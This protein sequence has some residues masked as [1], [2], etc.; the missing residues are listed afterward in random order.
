M[1]QSCTDLDELITIDVC[2][3]AKLECFSCKDVRIKNF[4]RI[5]Y[6]DG[7]FKVRTNAIFLKYPQLD[8]TST[9]IEIVYLRIIMKDSAGYEYEIRR[10]KCDALK[11]DDEIIIQNEITMFSISEKTIDLIINNFNVLSKNDFSLTNLRRII[12]NKKSSSTIYFTE[13]HPSFSS[14]S[15]EKCWFKGSVLN[16]VIGLEISINSSTIIFLQ[17]EITGFHLSPNNN[18]FAKTDIKNYLRFLKI[19][20]QFIE[21]ERKNQGNYDVNDFKLYN[22][23]SRIEIQKDEKRMKYSLF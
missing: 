1:N 12:L 11:F 21:I 15:E 2:N 6:L 10:S 18:Y 16:S 13:E 14:L 7:C 22:L 4:L 17:K 20:Q 8:I 3:Y 23:L 9:S 19:S 5:T